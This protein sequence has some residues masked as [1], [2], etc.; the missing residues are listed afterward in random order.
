M[1]FERLKKEYDSCLDFGI[2]FE[3]AFDGNRCAYVDFF[4]CDSYLF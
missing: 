3:E 1:G 4:T 2:I